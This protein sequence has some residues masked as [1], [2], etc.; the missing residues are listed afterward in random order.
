M[1]GPPRAYRH[2][3]EVIGQCIVLYVCLMGACLIT[4][5]Q[6]NRRD[7]LIDRKLTH[8]SMT[9]RDG[10]GTWIYRKVYDKKT[11][12]LAQQAVADK[13]LKQC[14]IGLDVLEGQWKA[15]KKTELSL[16]ARESFSFSLHAIL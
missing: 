8:I 4:E 16:K 11:G 6:L 9:N 13:G 15:Q 7:F 10:L 14:G 5:K 2:M 3:S 1:V 12:V